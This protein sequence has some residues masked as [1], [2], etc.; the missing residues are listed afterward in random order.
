VLIFSL[1]SNFLIRRESAGSY[2]GDLRMANSM[3]IKGDSIIT[4]INKNH[5][6]VYKSSGTGFSRRSS[7]D[8]PEAASGF[9]TSFEHLGILSAGTGDAETV[10]GVRNAGINA[11]LFE[12]WFDSAAKNRPMLFYGGAD[13]FCLAGKKGD[14]WYVRSLD[15]HG[16]I[17][18][19]QRLDGIENGE[20]LF[21]YGAETE[22]KARLYF[23]DPARRLIT[24]YEKQDTLWRIADRVELPVEIP[25]NDVDWDGAAGKRPLFSGDN[26]ITV[27]A[28]GGTLFYETGT[29]RIG[30]LEN[31]AIHASRN[32]NA[33]T[34]CAVYNSGEIALFR[35]GDIK[36][37]IIEEAE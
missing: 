30:L 1:D 6:E 17:T 32:I 22:G 29:G 37:N 19:E 18:G 13:S 25:A 35:M 21:A 36:G 23:F 20:K 2:E 10:Y 15:L 5:V 27:N 7:F 4:L 33:V 28:K 14:E 8:A 26:L 3:D 34:Y 16:T 24:I 12:A 9:D 31:S 11:P